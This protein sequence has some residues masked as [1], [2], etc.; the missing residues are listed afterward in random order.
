MAAYVGIALVGPI[1]TESLSSKFTT[2][3]ASRKVMTSR[4]LQAAVDHMPVGSGL[5]SFQNVYRT[6]ED[7]ADADHGFA[8]HAHNEYAE[9]ALELGVPGIL[10]VLLFVL[11]WARRSYAAWAG[12]YSGVALAR[13]A[14]T[15]ILIVL[16]HSL[17]DYPL[18]TSAVAALFAAACAMLL[19]APAGAASRRRAGDGGAGEGATRHLQA[20]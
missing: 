13:A 1:S 5:G 2:A 15:V 8:N 14:S 20:D 9:I 4:T 16:F 10:L 17:V 7:P 3:P 12:E 19:P 11:W 6:Y 18:R